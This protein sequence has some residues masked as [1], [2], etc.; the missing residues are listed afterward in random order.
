[1]E[2]Y[3]IVESN[4]RPLE[5]DKESAAD[6][7][8]IRRNIKELTR[9]N[10][11][12]ETIT[13]FRYEEAFFTISEYEKEAN[14]LLILEMNGDDNTAE[15]E[16]YQKKLDTG[17][18]YTNGKKYKP[19]WAD[20]YCK[21]INEILPI[22]TAYKEVGGESS[23]ALDLKINIYD[24]TGLPENAVAMSVKEIIELW[25]FLL[26]AQEALFNEYKASLK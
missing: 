1:M 14:R 4:T 5:I 6:G 22:L 11:A 23:A 24:E 12:G 10:D 7:I 15:F 2:N 17:I 16:A 9:E 25:F 21:R 19:K 8:Y 3:K 26:K 13:Y 20:I 18:L